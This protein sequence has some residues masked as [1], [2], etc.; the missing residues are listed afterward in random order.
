MTPRVEWRVK[1]GAWHSLAEQRQ[2]AYSLLAEVVGAAVTVDH[3]A[4]GAPF[5]PDHPEL[6]V[7]IS[8]CPTAVAAA[9]AQ[10]RNIGIDVESRR[11]IDPSLVMRVCIP[12][13]VAAVQ[14]AADPTMAFLRF[15]TRKEAVLKCR[16]TGIKGFGSMLEAASPTDCTLHDIDTL[17]PDTV[18]S[19]ALANECPKPDKSSSQTPK[20]QA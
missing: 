18:A 16:G 10:G 2:A 17:L 3:D 9:V 13:E 20:L 8:H 14:A 5:L 4:A 12:D 19:V 11:R 7:S 6:H 15:W 1:S